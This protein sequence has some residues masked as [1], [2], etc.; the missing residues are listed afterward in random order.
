[1]GWFT[2]P[3]IQEFQDGDDKTLTL[4]RLILFMHSNGLI[5]ISVNLEVILTM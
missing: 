4:A 1:M 3:A 5:I 2:H